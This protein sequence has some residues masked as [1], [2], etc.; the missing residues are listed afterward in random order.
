MKAADQDSVLLLKN[1]GLCQRSGMR[2]VVW[3]CRPSFFARMRASRRD[4]LKHEK[5]DSILIWGLTHGNHASIGEGG[6]H[7]M[8]EQDLR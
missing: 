6:K 8:F 4:P 3:E 2:H 1:C 7:R 5:N